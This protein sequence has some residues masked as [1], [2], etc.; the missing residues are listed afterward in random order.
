MTNKENNT[1]LNIPLRANKQET[2]RNHYIKFLPV[3][4]C[5]T[6]ESCEY[7]VTPKREVL[8]MDLL[9]KYSKRTVLKRELEG[10][11]RVLQFVKAFK[12]IPP[13]FEVFVWSVLDEG[14]VYKMNLK[15]VIDN[16]ELLWN[17]Y[18]KHDL[19]IISENGRVGLMVSEYPGYVDSSFES[20][21]ILY[22]VK[23]WG[24]I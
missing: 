19:T 20:D 1:F 10:K 14:P 22:Q 23:K 11:E 12:Q 3:P 21:E 24:L 15:W 16:F 4:V 6:V 17:E 18:N 2:S 7:I 5:E 9:E 8:V 13:H